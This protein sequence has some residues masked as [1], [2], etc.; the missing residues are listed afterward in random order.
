MW[1]NT[2]T[3]YSIACRI[4][5]FRTYEWFTNHWHFLNLIESCIT[6]ANFWRRSKTGIALTYTVFGWIIQY[7][8]SR[9]NTL[10]NSFSIHILSSCFMTNRIACNKFMRSLYIPLN[11]FASSYK[12]G[13][14]KWKCL[15]GVS[16]ASSNTCCA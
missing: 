4:W 16:R 13:I 6:L 7:R 11:T 8:E 14:D 10:T 3:Y 5:K 12:P 9:R 15:K 2:L 1:S